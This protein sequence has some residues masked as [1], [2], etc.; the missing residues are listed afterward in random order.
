MSFKDYLIEKEQW[1]V[2]SKYGHYLSNTDGVLWSPDIKV[3]LKFPSKKAGEDF[4]MMK[5]MKIKDLKGTL[6]KE[7]I[8]V[9]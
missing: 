8:K 3:A 1:I 9:D 4:E 7:V 5:G 6:A 2:K